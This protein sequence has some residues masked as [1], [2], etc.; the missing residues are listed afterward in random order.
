MFQDDSQKSNG[1][2]STIDNQINVQQ[3]SMTTIPGPM[4][5]QTDDQYLVIYK[6]NNH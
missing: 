1:H 6:L 5:T 2:L 4:Q 3:E